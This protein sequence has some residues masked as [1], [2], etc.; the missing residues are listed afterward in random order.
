MTRGSLENVC[1]REERDGSRMSV[2]DGDFL[3]RS[4]TE[5]S[6][7]LV[8]V[9][10]EVP[11]GEFHALRLAR[12]S[13]GVDE[14]GEV[15]HLAG[16]EPRFV[17]VEVEDFRTAVVDLGEREEVVAVVFARKRVH[18][19]D[20]FEVEVV[21]DLQDALQQILVFDDDARCLGVAE[22]VPNL[23]DGGTSI[24]GRHD[25]TRREQGEVSL[26]PLHAR[27][28]EDT[29]SVVGPDAEVAEPGGEVAND[30]PHRRVRKR[31]KLAVRCRRKHG[32]GERT[33]IHAA[34]VLL[35]GA[36]FVSLGA[37]LEHSGQRRPLDN[38]VG[39]LLLSV[40][41]LHTPH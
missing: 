10:P 13:A 24:H 17:L 8:D 19:D 29:D 6:V 21:F 23:R 40:T 34:L 18:H 5:P 14:R 38:R 37:V 35:C 31:P 9:R 4:G 33:A 39:E 22:E 27:V 1:E 36:V 30:V 16:F 3:V 7:T 41:P 12:R 15:V 20:E 28:G 11:V 25:G 32:F 26:R 2:D